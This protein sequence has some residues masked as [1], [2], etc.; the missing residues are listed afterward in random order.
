MAST[1]LRRVLSRRPTAM[2]TSRTRRCSLASASVAGSMVEQDHATKRRKVEEQ[3]G[4]EADHRDGMRYLEEERV[5]DRADE[6]QES[7][8]E[9]WRDIKPLP[10]G[11]E[12]K[13]DKCHWDYLL[14]EM[15][16]LAKDVNKE[17]KWKLAQAKKWS[18]AVVRSNLDVESRKRKRIKDAEL[19]RKKTAAWIAKQVS[20]FWIQV[21]KLVLFKHQVSYEQQK[22]KAL[23]VRLE[24]LLGQTETYTR[25][26]AERILA[27]DQSKEMG[28]P[29]LE[30]PTEQAIR[31]V[32]VES[33]KAQSSHAQEIEAPV[34][35][36]TS[37]SQHSHEKYRDRRSR[38]RAAVR[39]NK[40]E[41]DSQDEMQLH[42]DADQARHATDS[43]VAGVQAFNSEDAEDSMLSDE[44]Y[45][46]DSDEEGDDMGTFMEE[47]ERAAMEGDRER[48][49]A[50]ELEMLHEEQNVSIEELLRL[51]TS[52][53][54]EQ[55][56]SNVGGK[57]SGSQPVELRDLGTHPQED[58]GSLQ[59]SD[60]NLK[61]LA[62]KHF[63]G[64]RSD[65]QARA[66]SAEGCK[67]ES[68]GHGYAKGMAGITDEAGPSRLRSQLAEHHAQTAIGML[69]AAARTDARK[70]MSQH[71]EKKIPSLLEDTDSQEFSVEGD[72]G[73]YILSGSD[74]D[75]EATLEEEER[76]ARL[77]GGSRP[78]EEIHNLEDEA[79]MPIEAL[80]AKYRQANSS[81][82]ENQEHST[83]RNAH[84][85]RR[86]ARTQN[87]TNGA[88][89]KAALG[90][91]DTAN[92]KDVS[93]STQQEQQDF[94]L[95]ACDHD[96][97]DGSHEDHD[98]MVTS[99]EED[100]ESTLEEEERLALA[101]RHD[102]PA[103]EINALQAEASL[104]ITELLEH[105]RTL[106]SDQV[107]PSKKRMGQGRESKGEGSTKGQGEIASG[108]KLLRAAESAETGNLP[109]TWPAKG[110]DIHG[111]EVEMGHPGDKI[112]KIE[113]SQPQCTALQQSRIRTKVPFLMKY[114]LR[115]YQHIGLDWLVS[116]HEKRLNGILADEMGLGK[117]IQTIALLAH[118]AVEKGIWGP[119]LIV[120]PTSV[121]LN[122]EMEFFKFC[123]AFKVLTY[124]GT[125]KERKLKRQG[126]SKPN[127]FHVC[128]TTYTLILKDIK[129]LGRKKWKY[130]ILDE[131][132]M[133]K[134]WRSQRWQALLNFDAKHRL[135]LTGTPLQNDL[136]EL[137]ALLHFL[138]PHVFSSYDQ[139]SEWFSTPLTGMVEGQ[140]SVN[141]QIVQRLHKVLRPFLL[142]RIKRDVEKSL[143]PKEEHIVY[144]RLSKR[145]RE[146]YE[147]YMSS[148]STQKVLGSGNL[149]GIMNCLMQL[150]KVCNHPDLFES[151]PIV[152]AFDMDY[153]ELQVPS[154]VVSALQSALSPCSVWDLVD[155]KHLASNFQALVRTKSEMLFP[156]SFEP[157]VDFSKPRMMYK[158]CL[159]ENSNN[160][161]AAMSS[162]LEVKIRAERDEVWN[163]VVEQ[164]QVRSS[165]KTQTARYNVD[166][167]SCPT[168]VDS[169]QHAKVDPRKLCDHSCALPNMMLSFPERALQMDKILS[170]CCFVIPKA[171]AKAPRV[172]CANKYRKEQMVKEV[173]ESLLLAQVG[174]LLAPLRKAIV[175]HQLFF[176]DRRLIQFD[177]GKLQELATL[178]RHLR[179]DGHRCLI[180]TQMSKMLDVLESFLNL[181]GYTY[182]RLDG[183][184]KPEQRQ[185]LMQRFN[186]NPKIFCFILST[187]S[188][189][190][191]MNL[192]GADTVIF[193]DSD[194][195]PAMDAQAQDRAHR[196]GQTKVVHVYRLVSYGT[197]EENIL[198]KSRQ[199]QALDFLAIQSG[200]FNTEFFK[201]SNLVE[202]FDRKPSNGAAGAEQEDDVDEVL[203][204]VEDEADVA[205]TEAARKEAEQELAEFQGE[206]PIQE[207]NRAEGGEDG[208]KNPIQDL[209]QA[210]AGE[211]AVHS[212][213]QENLY[214]EKV[215]R[216]VAIG[217]SW[218]EELLPVERYAIRFFE[219]H[220]AKQ[221]IITAD[222]ALA[223]E[224]KVW[225]K[226][227]QDTARKEM[228]GSTPQERDHSAE[229]AGV[230]YPVDPAKAAAA[231]R[232]HL[233]L[234]EEQQLQG[235]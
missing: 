59:S 121:M 10:K 42:E 129:I 119:H 136:M 75:N 132:H 66:P 125:A 115:E 13:R 217:A 87:L 224:E 133:I 150:R 16:W 191:G 116:L 229:E 172:W 8:K 178:L 166:I 139:F 230:P 141:A 37:N 30:L 15:Q 218:E 165:C 3:T 72:D 204:Q 235:Y 47:E 225:E 234:L 123:P 170:E 99:E 91:M 168:L 7:R 107:F 61:P 100:D 102:N 182:L 63:S 51:Y 114:P 144:C 186:T 179:M 88:E 164:I 161:V 231:Y 163:S 211:D 57:G 96:L 44:E 148:S 109:A 146:L 77:E 90:S 2:A 111:I 19:E 1:C 169:V 189:G 143:P 62:N 39:V 60:R 137:W 210:N 192:T 29:E 25:D 40:Q 32:K 35:V 185:I 14:E 92:G 198:K 112:D 171:R 23:Y 34:T 145:Q 65:T 46:A 48:Q 127:S 138:M 74:E 41:T 227:A 160:L 174:P 216:A 93:H 105:Y 58:L 43:E 206:G 22:K 199:K 9:R 54:A 26:M 73:S 83:R 212:D 71:V 135:L 56:D 194:W 140:S 187:R 202:I 118:L 209:D 108:E 159:S 188:G 157:V 130:L 200:D 104:P 153:I 147:D 52:M 175:H 195:N 36:G 113:S 221:R 128:I 228:P 38:S 21:E 45:I 222:V 80:L 223:H 180:F 142:R 50:R 97:V 106:D 190:L 85:Y 124:F 103:S 203:K 196:I 213:E 79:S 64:G 110:S 149:M 219:E 89:G 98:Y 76:M 226:Q 18:K 82:W 208:A 31:Q 173:Q 193:Y 155:G 126:W 152:S 11:P 162:Y 151:R 53:Q 94:A 84:G 158:D 233:K 6:I 207:G 12:P 4:G 49:E 70:S 154:L 201:K 232:E 86:H 5:L 167:L 177:C 176:P 181:Y 122:W 134:N 68:S 156:A 214:Q 95:L 131:A 184:T 197:I 205:A 67:V 27:D 69:P 28:K 215:E 81:E 33:R 120:V 17:R 117:T 20:R 220:Y 24:A 101:E 183:T 78:E 55:G